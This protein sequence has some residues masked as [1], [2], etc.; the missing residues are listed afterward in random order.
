MEDSNTK[1]EIDIPRVELY[2]ST[3]TYFQLIR[4]YQ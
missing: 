3:L 1:I 4:E 2:L